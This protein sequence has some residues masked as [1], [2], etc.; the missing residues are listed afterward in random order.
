[1]S[2]SLATRPKGTTLT[3]APRWMASLGMPKT[4]LVS[5]SCAIVWLPAARVTVAEDLLAA[6][7]GVRTPR[8]G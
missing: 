6:Y 2:I 7:P 1:M 4:T 5:S 3:A 8:P